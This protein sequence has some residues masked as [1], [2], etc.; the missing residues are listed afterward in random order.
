[1]IKTTS[2][3][4]MLACFSTLCAPVK[5]D[6]FTPSAPCSAPYN[7]LK[8]SQWEIDS[9]KSCIENFVNEMNSAA[10]THR[11]AANNAIDQWNRFA[12]GGY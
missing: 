3:I 12:R 2:M 9:F 7:G 10:S 6:M 1:M 11:N 8:A 5:G 4:L